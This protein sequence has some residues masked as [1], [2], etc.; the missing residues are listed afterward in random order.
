[1]IKNTFDRKLIYANRRKTQPAHVC[2]DLKTTVLF[3][4]NTGTQR[5]VQTFEIFQSIF[6]CEIIG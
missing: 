1:L 6:K 5:L 2:S 3:I 4:G